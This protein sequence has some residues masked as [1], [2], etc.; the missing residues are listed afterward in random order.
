MPVREAVVNL[1]SSH[2]MENLKSLVRDMEGKKGI[3]CFQMH[4]HRDEGK[5]RDEINYHAHLLFD[6]QDEKTGKT[7][8]LNKRDF[9][10]IQTL[11]AEVLE[12][13]RGE[14]RT[15]S[16]RERLEPVEYK[17]QQEEKRVKAL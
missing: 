17:R 1:N 13:E 11:V 2:S 9:S 5:S 7:V 8:K 10:E 12:M 14:L 4:I 6:W 3:K 15:N 16:N